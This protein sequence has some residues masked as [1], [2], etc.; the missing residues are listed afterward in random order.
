MATKPI[1]ACLI[2][3]GHREYHP[4]SSPALG[5]ARGSDRLSLTKNH[6]VPTPAFRAGAPVNPLG[7]P[8]LRVL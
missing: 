5:K 1:I 3:S 7:S 2:I 4:M 6:P 8:Q